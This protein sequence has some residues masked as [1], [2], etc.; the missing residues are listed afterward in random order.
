MRSLQQ[1]IIYCTRVHVIEQM[2][3]GTL[4]KLVEEVNRQYEPPPKATLTLQRGKGTRD[5]YNSDDDEDDD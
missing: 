1:H 5:N 3:E 2:N 4:L